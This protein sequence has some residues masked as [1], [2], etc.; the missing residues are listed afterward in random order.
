MTLHPGT[1]VKLASRKAVVEAMRLLANHYESG[2]V[3][4]F[5]LGTSPMGT[6][7]VSAIYA[8]GVPPVELP[9]VAPEDDEA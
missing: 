6:A 1:V 7:R 3:V 2:D 4:D 5:S 9:G 8:P